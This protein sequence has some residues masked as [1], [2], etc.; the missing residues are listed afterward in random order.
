MQRCQPWMN[1]APFWR[2]PNDVPSYAGLIFT[3]SNSIN[4][5][6]LTLP[7]HSHQRKRV[8]DETISVKSAKEQIHYTSN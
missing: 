2:R 5:A 4:S 1:P 7:T 8:I 6:T 3:T